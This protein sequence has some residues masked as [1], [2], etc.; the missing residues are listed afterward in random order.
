[1]KNARTHTRNVWTRVSSSDTRGLSH[2]SIVITL[3]E[4]C[5]SEPCVRQ[6]HSLPWATSFIDH[7]SKNKQRVLWNNKYLFEIEFHFEISCHHQNKPFIK[8]RFWKRIWARSTRSGWKRSGH[9]NS[10]TVNNDFFLFI[11]RHLIWILLCNQYLKTGRT[12]R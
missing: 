6:Y 9:H 7:E 11:N 4:P 2:T 12:H 3:R 8:W 1:M 5:V 10:T